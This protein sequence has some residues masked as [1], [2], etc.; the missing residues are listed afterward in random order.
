MVALGRIAAPYGIKGWVHVQSYTQPASNILRYKTWY[1][2]DQEARPLRVLE[3][4]SLSKGCVVALEG[5]DN[6]ER[7]AE[8]RHAMVGV[9]REKLP[10]LEEGVYYWADL[11]GMQ[12]HNQACDPA[13]ATLG[14]VVEIFEAGANDVLVVEPE[15]S[16][17]SKPV[18]IPFLMGS[19]ITEVDQDAGWI[20]LEWDEWF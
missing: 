5:F 10:A 16:M 13:L 18:L 3:G 15:G 4:R 11:I 7:A 14:R 17:V 6:P 20:R 19:V 1:L 9:P 2:L 12:V 8:L